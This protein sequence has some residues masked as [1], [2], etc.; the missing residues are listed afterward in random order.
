MRNY[1]SKSNW[2]NLVALFGFLMFTVSVIFIIISIV[3]TIEWNPINVFFRHIDMF[4]NQSNFLLWV[5]ML[6]FIFFPKHSFLKNNKFLI[7]TMV[8]IF[9]TFIGY[10]AILV[11]NGYSYTGDAV[12]ITS[13]VW[14]HIL[15]PIY[16]LVF[17]FLFMFAN[18]NKEPKFLSTLF[19]GMIYPTIY[20]IYVIAVNYT[21][22]I[23]GN[24]YD[25]SN[26]FPPDDY[27]SGYYT[28]YGSATDFQYTNI[29]WV[30]TIGILFIFFP[31]FYTVFYYIWK[32]MNK[33]KNIF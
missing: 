20:V 2:I 31:G 27:P 13:N 6:F 26:V 3:S 32:G 29:A 8:Y 28:V 7:W 18:P 25:Y 5:F 19:C 33:W 24:N 1:F 12:T 14:R 22:K 21:F 16:F 4:T 23:V 15:S 30:Y 9:F 11:P 10:N 17:G